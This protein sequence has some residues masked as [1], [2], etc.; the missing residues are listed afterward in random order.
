MISFSVQQFYV[1]RAFLPNY[2]T[3]LKKPI[4][5]CLFE[6]MVN[7]QRKYVRPS[8]GQILETEA[9]LDFKFDQEIQ[10]L[11]LL[12]LNFEEILLLSL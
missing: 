6:I 11:N 4:K 9:K 7:E 12:V 1:F 5:N 10:K 8:Y 2:Y 3:E